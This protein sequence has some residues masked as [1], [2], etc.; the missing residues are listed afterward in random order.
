MAINVNQVDDDQSSLAVSYLNQKQN[1]YPAGSSVPTN[2]SSLGVATGTVASPGPSGVGG[3]E[4]PGKRLF[5][6]LSKLA[7]YTYQISWYMITPDAYAEFVNSGRRNIDALKTAGPV[8]NA[9][10]TGAGA[11]AYLIAQSGGINN[12]VS[13]RAPGFELDYYIDQL[14]F[15]TFVGAKGTGT[16]T[17]TISDIT[18]QVTEPYGFSF[19]TNLK[20][21]ADA[22]K[23]YTDSTSYKSLSNNFKNIFILGIRFYGY[24]INGNLIKPSDSLYGAPIDP[25]GSDALFENFYDIEISNVKFRLDGKAVVY[26]V[27]AISI[28]AHALLGVK[29]GRIPTGV[30]VQ[31]K[32]VN[33][34]LQGPDGLITK[35]NQIEQ[36]KVDKNPADAS[37]PNKFKIVYQ[38]DAESRIGKASMVT[39]S[40]LDKIKWPGSGAKTTTESTDAKGAKPPDPNE[41]MLIF[42]N[43]V[44][45]IQAI[46]QIIKRSTYME[47]ALKT[48]YANT[49]EPDVD[50][51]NNPQVKRD[52]PLPLAWFSVSSEI[53]KCEWDPKISDWAYEQNFIISVYEIPSVQTPYAPDST[54]YYGPHKRYDYFFTGQNSEI[55]EYNLQ[56]DNLYFNTVLGIESKDFASISGA[57]NPGAEREGQAAPAGGSGASTGNTKTTSGNTGQKA[58]AP[59]PGAKD[60]SAGTA[61]AGGTSVKTGVKSKGDRTGTLAVGL[62]VQN[63]IVTSLHDVAA[64]ANGKLRIL[65]DPDFLIR[66]A[67]TSIASLYNK[68]YDTDG[69]TISANGGQI[70]I[71]VAFKEAVD[72]K[73]STGLMQINENIFFLNYPQYIKD[74]TQGAVIW[75]VTDVIS[76]FAGGRFEQTL[77]LVGPAFDTGEPGETSTTAATSGSGTTTSQTAP[78]D[79]D[80]KPLETEPLE[81]LDGSPRGG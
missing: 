77:T 52:N 23:A 67:S 74:M 70:F 55:L 12:K 76:S 8:S 62:E 24:D 40:D 6:P 10:P 43:D 41:R 75:E 16:S 36:G 72:Y 51:K 17:T 9:N 15:N 73:N 57:Q 19:L 3:S 50:Q 64:Y 21:A 44:S 39:Q 81:N 46:E 54:K 14:K 68:F 49:K 71:E 78:Q 63:S 80:L 22:L 69:Y 47:N 27:E 25:A 2:I 35:L 56:F 29:R 34:A 31:G 66:D 20:R 59:P 28:N 60:S 37:I 26:N 58:D 32:N 79:D 38:G 18:F 5:N 4:R 7:S 33:D 1:V 11:G 45:I 42:N 13:R 65:G 30:K 48:V 53:V 61:T